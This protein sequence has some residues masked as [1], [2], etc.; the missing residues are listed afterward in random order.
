MSDDEWMHF[1]LALHRYI[2]REL[3]LCQSD[4]LAASEKV[5]T[6]LTGENTPKFSLCRSTFN[7]IDYITIVR[8][9]D[10]ITTCYV[11]QLLRNFE[12]RTCVLTQDVKMLFFFCPRSFEL[13]VEF[14]LSLLQLL[15]L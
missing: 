8:F 9:C 4:F 14:F 3:L 6:H 10:A 2:E 1:S 13:F 7:A 12:I 11:L 15:E 5:K